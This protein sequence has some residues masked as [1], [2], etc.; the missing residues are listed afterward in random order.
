MMPL[1]GIIL[2]DVDGIGAVV[3]EFCPT[4]TDW[5]RTLAEIIIKSSRKK[6]LGLYGTIPVVRNPDS[7]SL[8][9]TTV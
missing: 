2:S 6:T 9:D 4:T 3:A 8:I 1:V 5:V 7:P